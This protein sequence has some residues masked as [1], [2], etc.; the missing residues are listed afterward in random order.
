MFWFPAIAG[1][2]TLLIFQ[3]TWAS[4]H[5]TLIVAIGDSTTAGTPFFRSPLESP[6]EGEGDPE[7]Q[8]TYWMMRRRPQWNVLNYGIKGETSGQIRGRLHDALKLQP[9][10]II[11]L[12]GANDV[13]RGFPLSAIANNL[14]AMYK[15]AE[16]QNV[17]PVAAT[18]LPYNRT[19][20]DQAKAI[21]ALNAWIKKAS[22]RLHIPI[23]DLNAAVRDPENADRLNGSPD[24]EHPD[25]GG[26]RKMG[27]TLIAAIDPIE[28]AWR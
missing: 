26:Y 6:P 11:I 15:E 7:G 3:S 25:V 5:N 24:D 12:A 27:M 21:K 14:L 13:S 4:E 18:V 23:A 16:G 9:R 20:P 8:F 19:S 2:T 1:M 22:D 10:C 28:K 17:L